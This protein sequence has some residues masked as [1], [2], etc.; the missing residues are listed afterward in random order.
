MAGPMSDPS[1]SVD[2]QP[3]AQAGYDLMA[4]CFEVHNVLGG[5]LT[6]AIYQE[7]LEWEL[8]LR[9]I[10]FISKRQLQVFYKGHE[11][12]T[13]YVPDLVVS[14]HIVVELK[15]LKET[16]SDHEGQL[17]NYLR[18]AKQPVGY[19]I[20]FAPMDKV[21]WKRFVLSEF[22]TKDLDR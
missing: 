14:E 3:F 22:I 4:A 10:Q 12:E 1:S 6:E 2:N 9:N 19:L 15:S 13:R 11:L 7:S 5:G 20:N 21:N 17:F 18:I 16:V 8:S